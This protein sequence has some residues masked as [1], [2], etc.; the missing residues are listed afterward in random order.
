VH[1]SA[2]NVDGESTWKP[3]AGRQA[4]DGDVFP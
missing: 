2:A 3:A 1:E 4:L